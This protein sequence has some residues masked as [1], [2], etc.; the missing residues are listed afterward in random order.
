MLK[1]TLLVKQWLLVISLFIVLVAPYDSASAQE[2]QDHET[3]RMAGKLLTRNGEPMS[4]GLVYLSSSAGPVPDPD[5]Y[6]KVPEFVTDIDDTGEFT[7]ELPAGSYYLGA[8]KR[9]SGK[10]DSGPPHAGDLFY[11][12]IDRKGVPILFVIKKGENL[13]IGTLSGAVPFKGAAAGK[14]ISGIAGKVI[15]SDGKPAVGALVFAFLSQSMI[16]RPA[17]ASDRTGK[18]G[19]YLLR[20]QEGGNYYLRARDIYGG[21]PPAAEAIMGNFGGATPEPVS[22]KQGK[23]TKGIDIVVQ[24]FQGRGP[25]GQEQQG[26]QQ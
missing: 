11:K 18:D 22:V 23:I 25:Q 13:N 16:G 7:I 19:A 8:I 4:G 5:R 6:W 17:F 10:T 26:P 12:G 2:Q 21:G 1:R 14:T 24:K 9:I 15:T 3:G 20:V